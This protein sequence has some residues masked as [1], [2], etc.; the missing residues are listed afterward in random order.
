MIESPYPIE[1]IEVA[2]AT[3]RTL[4]QSRNVNDNKFSLLHQDLP[5]GTY[6][7]KIYSRKLYTAKLVITQ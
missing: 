6:F 2:D 7:I 1:K 5:P 3:G 4:Y